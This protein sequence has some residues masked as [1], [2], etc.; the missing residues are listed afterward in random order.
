MGVAEIIQGRKV[1]VKSSLRL[2]K[3]HA[4]KTHWPLLLS[5][6]LQ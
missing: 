4:I 1:K 6:Y 5:C 3:H 2:T